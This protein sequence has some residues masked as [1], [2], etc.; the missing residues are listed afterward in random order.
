MNHARGSPRALVLPGVSAEKKT[1]RFP[2]TYLAGGRK[3]GQLSGRAPGSPAPDAQNGLQVG[4]EVRIVADLLIDLQAIALAVGNDDRVAVRIE[5]DRRREA[6][7]PLRFEALHA[8][9]RLHHVRVGID[10][11]LAPFRQLLGIADQRGDRATFGIENADPVVAPIAHIDVAVAVDRNI[12]RVIELV[13]PGMAGLLAIGGD[14]RPEDR[15]RI[16]AFRLRALAEAADAHQRLALRRQFL[17]AVVVPVGDKDVAVLVEGDAPGLVELARALAGSAAFGEE[18]AV[19]A[20]DLQAVIA[21]VGDDQIAALL[22]RETGR[23]QQFPVAAAGRSP[24]L[25]ELPAGVEYRDRI[26]PLIRAV[27][28]VPLLVDRDAERPDRLAVLFAVFVEVVEQLLFAGPAELHLVGVHPEIVLVAPVGGVDDPVLAEA[29]RLD[30]IEPGAPGGAPPDGVAP[31]EHPS[32]RDR[33]QRHSSLLSTFGLPDGKTLSHSAFVPRP[34][35][36]L[37]FPLQ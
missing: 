29:H 14:I 27:D 34:C 7:P 6:E 16:G 21:A 33:C 11:L 3:N 23:T 36:R 20:E 1:A 35:R 22:D 37:P 26:G 8:T 5:V 15:H 4:L 13:G 10:A 19:R 28:P 25:E 17:D 12:G 31:I 24:F 32:A 30:V 18:L 2:A 9:A